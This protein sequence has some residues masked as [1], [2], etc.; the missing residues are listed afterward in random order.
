MKSLSS[1]ALAALQD[2]TA[3]VTGALE[4]AADPPLRVWG[5]YGPIEIE[6]HTYDPL[7]DRGLAEV[8]GGALGGAAQGI[9]LTLSAIEPVLL[10]LLDADEVAQAPGALWRL[11]FAGD[12]IT[13][14]DAHV[15]ARGRLDTL[16]R[17][18][19][20]GGLATLSAQL[21]TA[22]RGLGRSGARM[23]S[24]ADQR[25]IKADDGFFRNATFAAEKT[26]YWGGRRPS[27][28]GSAVGGSYYGGG[29]GVG[30]GGDADMNF[31][32]RSFDLMN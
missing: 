22:A 24:D 2:G 27:N 19:D 9:T 10:D 15:W 31:G 5:G 6:G 28:A 32:G 12:G 13:L 18:E 25:L 29:G 21:E 20:V 1:A 16:L 11:I 3:I 17:D 8:A 26:L 4:I 30:G 23:R 14:L 7:G